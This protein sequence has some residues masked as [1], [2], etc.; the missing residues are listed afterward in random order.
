MKYSYDYDTKA[1]YIELSDDPVDETHQLDAGTMVDLD[2]SGG[3]VGIEV[4]RPGRPWPL[5]EIM[6]RFPLAEDDKL[7]LNSMWDTVTHKHWA[8]ATPLGDLAPGRV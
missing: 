8:F 3:V 7:L 4:L 1:L 2:E 6:K 5:D